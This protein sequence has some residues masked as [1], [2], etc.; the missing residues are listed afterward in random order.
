M[1]FSQDDLKKT[2]KQ[3]KLPDFQ[4]RRNQYLLSCHFQLVSLLLSL[5][6]ITYY[7]PSILNN[8]L[9]PMT[10]CKFLWALHY[11]NTIIQI[12]KIFSQVIFQF[13]LENYDH[14]R[15]ESVQIYWL[16]LFHQ[17]DVLKTISLTF[18]CNKFYTKKAFFTSRLPLPQCQ[19]NQNF[20][21]LFRINPINLFN[22]MSKL[23]SIWISYL[24][25]FLVYIIY[26]EEF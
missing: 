9:P 14:I 7:F 1:Q 15:M 10:L 20:H 22:F 23:N 25:E 16:Y 4:K 5:F 3:N 18:F 6:Q 13:F 12:L 11:S 21:H 24:L 8:N 17:F 2:L 26:L 19:I